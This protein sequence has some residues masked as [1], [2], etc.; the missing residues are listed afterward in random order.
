[1]IRAFVDADV[2]FSASYS[3]AGASREIIRLALRGHVQLIISDDVL[4]EAERNLASKYPETVEVFE[5]TIDS[6]PFE[7]VSASPEQV[8][9]AA[10]YT[11]SKDAH[12]VAA[13][14]EAKADF[15]VSLDKRHLVGV[16]EVSKRSGI[17][18]VFPA[19]LLEEIR[20]QLNC[21]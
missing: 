1:M 8:Q 7:K 19:D 15:L 21:G 17:E 10:K 20:R 5:Q 9:K 6:V 18:I 13:A 3:S 16:P 4:D 12:V 14:I 11:R 2:L